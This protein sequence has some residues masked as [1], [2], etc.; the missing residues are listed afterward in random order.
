M[1]SNRKNK[2][3]L[4]A[5]LD[6]R[7]I[8]G[9]ETWLNDHPAMDQTAF[10]ITAV[11]EKLYRA[12]IFLP[13]EVFLSRKLRKPLQSRS[14]NQGERDTA[15]GRRIDSDQNRKLTL[16][17]APTNRANK[18]LLKAWV[19]EVVVGGIERWLELH[20]VLNRTDFLLEAVVAKLEN[21]GIKLPRGAGEKKQARRPLHN[22]A[23]SGVD[24]RGAV[25]T[26]VVQCTESMQ[27]L[28]KRI[29]WFKSSK[30]FRSPMKELRTGKHLTQ[31]VLKRL[32]LIRL[33]LKGH[34][35]EID[36]L[37]EK[38]EPLSEA[39]QVIIRLAKLSKRFAGRHKVSAAA[40]DSNSDNRSG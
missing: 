10:L 37:L 12:N 35:E 31:S 16:K 32:Q 8:K 39:D 25:L 19:D 23:Y 28:V 17:A 9:V 27:N 11:E 3:L 4:G 21:D 2:V 40:I 6:S 22:R 20:P 30:Q 38:A 5:W 33:K 15:L 34:L 26:Q 36:Q 24:N 1:A 14:S 18:M 13:R 7:V 29:D